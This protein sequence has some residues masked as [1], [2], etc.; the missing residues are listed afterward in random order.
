L[1]LQH[2]LIAVV[3]SDAQLVLFVAQIAQPLRLDATVQVHNKD[4][5]GGP[6]GIAT[7]ASA[8]A[9]GIAEKKLRRTHL[10]QS[11]ETQHAVAGIVTLP[12]VH[13]VSHV[14]HGRDKFAGKVLALF[15]T[16]VCVCRN[17]SSIRFW[18]KSTPVRRP[19]RKPRYQ[20]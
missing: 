20:N 7:T 19:A 4:L 15:A 18:A 8:V 10:V 6:G 14:V 2:A 17:A 3:V 13:A 12:G 9:A 5:R 11:A 1:P 16:I